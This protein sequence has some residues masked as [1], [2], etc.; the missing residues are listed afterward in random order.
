[1]QATLLIYL[2]GVVH[3]PQGT[4]ALLMGAMGAGA[5]LVQAV[6]MEPLQARLGNKRLLVL[7]LLSVGKGVVSM[8][9]PVLSLKLTPSASAPVSHLSSQQQ[10]WPSCPY[11]RAPS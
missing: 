2:D 6:L 1:M 5:F 3:M 7:A 8:C 11:S 10:T 4:V 9:V